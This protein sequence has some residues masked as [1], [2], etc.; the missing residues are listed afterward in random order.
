VSISVQRMIVLVS[1]GVTLNHRTGWANIFW[2]Y[3]LGLSDFLRERLVE[4]LKAEES[5]LRS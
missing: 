3:S 1:L 5:K 4:K 2:L